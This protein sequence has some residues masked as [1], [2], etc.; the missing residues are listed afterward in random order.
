MQGCHRKDPSVVGPSAS[1]AA[2]NVAGSEGAGDN[3]DNSDDRVIGSQGPERS[4]RRDRGEKGR[5]EACSNTTVG[6]SQLGGGVGWGGVEVD[7]R[8]VVSA[9]V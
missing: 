4:D 1:A 9:K 5:E 8:R 7:A 3:V 6:R 2:I